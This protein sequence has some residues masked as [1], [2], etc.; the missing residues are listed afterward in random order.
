[1]KEDRRLRGVRAG[2]QGD[3][4]LHGLYVS[5]EDDLMRL[6]GSERI[7]KLMD[8]M[9]IEE[10]EVIQH[11]MIALHPYLLNVMRPRSKKTFGIS[12][13]LIEYDDVMNSQREV[14]YKND[15]MRFSVN[16]EYR[17][18]QYGFTIPVEVL[19]NT[20]IDTRDYQA[21]TTDLIRVLSIECPVSEQFKND[22]AV[23]TD[24]ISRKYN[25]IT[26]TNRC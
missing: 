20:H 16:A 11:S 1:M 5:L 9:G 23:T 18:H 12:K 14:V 25:A 6:F 19:V 3:R 15:V 21:F 2:R 10:G 24:K 8:R 17:Y 22:K 4:D 7:M 26:S 13:R